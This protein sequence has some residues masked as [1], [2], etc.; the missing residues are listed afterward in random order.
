MSVNDL[1][2]II[3]QKIGSKSK[4]KHI[5]VPKKLEEFQVMKMSVNST[6]LK[7]L[8]NYKQSTNFSDGLKKII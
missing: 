4:I 6:K 3:K 8:I 1:A 7:K 5:K 2:K